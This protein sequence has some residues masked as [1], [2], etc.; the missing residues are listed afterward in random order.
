MMQIKRDFA[1]IELINLAGRNE[2]IDS[3]LQ[4]DAYMYIFYVSKL[5]WLMRS[6][7]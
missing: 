3:I 1:N 5:I 6:R 2:F 4:V 7:W